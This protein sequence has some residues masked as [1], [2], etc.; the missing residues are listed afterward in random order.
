MFSKDMLLKETSQKS[1]VQE[2]EVCEA[3]GTIVELG[4]VLTEDDIQL[5]LPFSGPTKESVEALTEKYI[6][7]AKARFE[8]VKITVDYKEV[9]STI[10]SEV[11]L[12]FEC[13]AE[14]LIFEMGLSAI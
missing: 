5:V 8:T 4:S 1:Q 3:C 10:E 13:T 9:E 6:K 14:K 12:Q 7:A 11:T 2:N